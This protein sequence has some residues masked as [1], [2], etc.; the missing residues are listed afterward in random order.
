MFILARDWRK[1]DFTN[2]VTA[3]KRSESANAIPM[4]VMNQVHFQQLRIRSDGLSDF[5]PLMDLGILMVLRRR[6]RHSL[7]HK[8][9]GQNCPLQKY[10]FIPDIPISLLIPQASQQ[11]WIPLGEKTYMGTFRKSIASKDQ[12]SSPSMATLTYNM[13]ASNRKT[14]VRNYVLVMI[15]H[16]T[17]ITSRQPKTLRLSLV[18]VS[19]Q[20]G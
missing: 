15:P 20:H 1:M 10:K 7:L 13:E 2:A 4:V 9:V 18:L 17:P 11:K 16:I 3:R 12:P 5:Y 8:T 14:C 19:S 6:K